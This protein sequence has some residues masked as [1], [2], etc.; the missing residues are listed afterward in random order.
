MNRRGFLGSLLAA[1]AW[2]LGLPA[3]RTARPLEGRVEG[4]RFWPGVALTDIQVRY[5]SRPFHDAIYVWDFGDGPTRW[6]ASA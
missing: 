1:A 4:L 2:L 3:G 5:E 6:E